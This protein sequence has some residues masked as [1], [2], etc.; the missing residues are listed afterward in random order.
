M[1]YRRLDTSGR[2]LI[3]ATSVRTTRKS[4]RTREHTRYWFPGR[5]TGIP[6]AGPQR[7]QNCIITVLTSRSANCANGCYLPRAVKPYFVGE[8]TVYIRRASLMNHL[9][10]GFIHYPHGIFG[11]SRCSF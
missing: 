9:Q 10:P 4:K 6:F 8:N 3:S 5:R 7:S 1:E 2:S 11:D